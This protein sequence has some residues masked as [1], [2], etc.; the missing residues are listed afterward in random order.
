MTDTTFHRTIQFSRQYIH[1]RSTQVALAVGIT[2]YFAYSATHQQWS[3]PALIGVCAFVA[4]FLPWYSRLSNMVEEKANLS[5]ALVTV[6]RVSRFILQLVFNYLI[7]TAFRLGGVLDSAALDGVDGFFGIAVL[8]TIAS[9]GAQYVA[10]V[11]FNR[12]IGDL[13]RNLILALSVNILVTAAATT[14]IPMVKPLFVSLS[15][16]LGARPG[17]PGRAGRGQQA[18]YSRNEKTHVSVGFF[19]LNESQKTYTAPTRPASCAC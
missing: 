2:M 6:G 4:L 8:T 10:V 13:N 19:V 9:Q 11:L 14:G 12:G 16:L 18:S 7:F 3:N 17:L 15:L 1:S 5:L